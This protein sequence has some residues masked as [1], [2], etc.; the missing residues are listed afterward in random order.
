MN[1]PTFRVESNSPE[2]SVSVRLGL[3]PTAILAVAFVA[4]FLMLSNAIGKIPA[5]VVQVNPTPVNVTV[6]PAPAAK[7]VV[8]PRIVIKNVQ[9]DAAVPAD[10]DSDPNPD[11]APSS[12]TS[13]K[14]IIPD[15]LKSAMV[16]MGFGEAVV[17]ASR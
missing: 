3:I 1:Y 6:S 15:S 8:R 12:R 5:E 7:I 17:V 9:V 16:G 11:P 4:S 10:I 13:R 14:P 2:I